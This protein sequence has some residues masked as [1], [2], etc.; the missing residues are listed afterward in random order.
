L[1]IT[2]CIYLSSCSAANVCN[3]DDEGIRLVAEVH[4]GLSAL[5]GVPEDVG[6]RLL[7]DPVGGVVDSGGERDLLSLD[8]DADWR[9][10]CRDR[11]A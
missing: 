1:G 4:S 7:Q 11:V 5:A 10:G 8:C 3:P 2:S 9:A 6:E